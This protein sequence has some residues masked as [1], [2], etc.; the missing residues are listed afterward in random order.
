[1][2]FETRLVELARSDDSGREPAAAAAGSGSEVLSDGKSYT[3]LSAEVVSLD[4]SVGDLTDR[5][6]ALEKSASSKSKA[7]NNGATSLSDQKKTGGRSSIEKSVTSAVCETRL[8]CP[9]FILKNDHFAKT[10]S[11]QT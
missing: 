7:A 1:V 10:G 2:D 5:V 11:G 4:E 3:R 6:G 9:L 8:V